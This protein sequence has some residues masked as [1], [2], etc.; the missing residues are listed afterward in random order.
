MVTTI[1]LIRHG[2]T[3]GDEVKRYK[4]S[5]DIPLSD[6]GVEQIN[7]TLDFIVRYA[8]KIR[9]EREK[10]P[11]IEREPK[12]PKGDETVRR[13]LLNAVYTS[14]LKRAV[15][16]A[17]IVAKP[18]SLTPVE[19]PE[20]TE[21]NF[22]LWEG[23]TYLEIKEKYPLEFDR[24][25]KDP[26]SYSPPMGESTLQVRDRVLKCLEKIIE[27]HRA[28]NENIAIVAHGGVNRI[29]LC[30]FLG[31]PLENIFR[32]EQDHGGV[33]IIELWE[34]YPVVKLINGISF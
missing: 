4:G 13:P 8:Q 21:R 33:N 23:M 16:S 6:R 17:E 28:D 34:R 24:W 29:L 31:I 22:G 18:F 9:V 19:L 30:H 5:I 2:A 12:P 3:E 10:N 14:P 7:K 27:S 25:T 1:Y 26:L 32:I 11:L 20:L 15:K